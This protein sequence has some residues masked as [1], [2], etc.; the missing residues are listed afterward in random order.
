MLKSNPCEDGLR[1]AVDHKLS[2]NQQHVQAQKVFLGPINSSRVFRAREVKIPCTLYC[3]DKDLGPGLFNI[4]Q[5]GNRV[6]Y[7]YSG[8]NEQII[9]HGKLLKKV[10]LSNFKKS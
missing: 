9:L 3:L 10:G 2:V 1:V 5:K 4:F 7:V 8:K 6:V